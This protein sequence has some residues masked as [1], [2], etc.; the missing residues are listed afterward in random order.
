MST[1][2]L[3]LIRAYQYLFRP[4]LGANCRFAPSCSEYAREAIEKHGAGKGT[5]RKVNFASTGSD[6]AKSA[7]A[8]YTTLRTIANEMSNPPM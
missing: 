5:V 2:L 1:I 3:A 6:A 4:L 7:N 8:P